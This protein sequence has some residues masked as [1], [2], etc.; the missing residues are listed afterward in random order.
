MTL[1]LVS[2]FMQD[3]IYL[4]EEIE[5]YNKK[6]RPILFTVRGHIYS[7]SRMNLPDFFKIGSS[8]IHYKSNIS[9]AYHLAKGLFRKETFK[10][11]AYLIKSKKLSKNSLK[12]LV[13]FAAKSS[14][15]YEE[16]S[17]RLEEMD[18]KKDEKI[19]FYSYRVGF[20][21]LALCKLKETY[22][23]AKVVSRAHAQDIFEFRNKENY[24]PY[25]KYLYENIDEIFTISEDGL[26]YLRDR[27]KV[28]ENK[29]SLFRL[30]TRDVAIN[31]NISN[32]DF[33]IITCSRI[34][35][36]KRLDLLARS[37]K[38]IDEQVNWVHF[39]DGDEEYFKEIKDITN[40][41]KENIQVEFMGFCDNEK[42]LDIISKKPL[43]VFVNVS[44]S[45][46]LPVSIMEAESVGL[47]ILATDVGGTSESVIDGY[48]GSLVKKDISE[49][50]LAAS[51]LKFK[52]MPEEEFDKLKVNSRKIWED[53]F[54]LTSNYRDF[55]EHLRGF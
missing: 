26:N 36:I 6:D 11:L 27:Y 17:K 25:R 40:T 28:L 15:V 19:I 38:D 1:V 50:D 48:N 33:T 13:L 30:G 41:Y 43:S 5:Y 20:S 9:R 34:A 37:L 54:R 52:N 55:V 16:I 29:T 22:K 12:S 35:R 42:Y 8:D 44:E 3:E 45:E 23:N 49:K 21:T 24:L 39:G 32:K 31:N 14:L 2:D 51:I 7:N 53:R 18:I 10:D 4:N 47:P 46:G